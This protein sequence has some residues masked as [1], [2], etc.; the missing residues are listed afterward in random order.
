MRAC[1]ITSSVSLSLRLLQKDSSTGCAD[2]LMLFAQPFARPLTC[3]TCCEAPGAISHSSSLIRT[4]PF[5]GKV[6]MG[7]ILLQRR[8]NKSASSSASL[9]HL[10]ASALNPA[11]YKHQSLKFARVVP[12]RLLTCHRLLCKVGAL[13]TKMDRRS[14]A[15]DAR[16][17]PSL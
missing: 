9:S 11:R 6:R 2:I 13:L 5:Q 16:T 3:S 7:A 1:A 12:T 17:D 15:T 10:C 14:F 8:W 4:F